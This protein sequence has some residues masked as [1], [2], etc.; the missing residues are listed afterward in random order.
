ML[1]TNTGK[2]YLSCLRKIELPAFQLCLA[3]GCSGLPQFAG[4]STTSLSSRLPVSSCISSRLCGSGGLPP[5]LPCL[6]SLWPGSNYSAKA[7][8]RK[9]C[10]TIR[11]WNLKALRALKLTSEN[12]SII[13]FQLPLKAQLATKAQLIEVGA[14]AGPNALP[15]QGGPLKLC[16]GNIGLS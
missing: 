4:H 2:H 7:M 5:L 15:Y 3:F 16:P 13:K 1:P 11:I 12:E 14:L 6:P 9:H 8:I 10:L